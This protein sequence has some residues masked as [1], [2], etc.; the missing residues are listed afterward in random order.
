MTSR[1]L[2]DARFLASVVDV[3]ADPAKLRKLDVVVLEPGHSA[4]T[5]ERKPEPVGVL[6]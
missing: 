5:R 3:V 4:A 6:L 1:I 2:A